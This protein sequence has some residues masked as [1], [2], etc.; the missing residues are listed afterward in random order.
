MD[1]VRAVLESV[2]RDLN[3]ERKAVLAGYCRPADYEEQL[4]NVLDGPFCLKKW[5]WRTAARGELH[6]V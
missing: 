2:V 6:A 4:G 1:Q 3:C 5:T